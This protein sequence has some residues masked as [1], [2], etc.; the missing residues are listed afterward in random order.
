MGT[1]VAT[2]LNPRPPRTFIKTAT[3]KAQGYVII[4]VAMSSSYATNGDTLDFSTKSPPGMAPTR[5]MA[6]P[7][8]GYVPEYDLTNKKMKV[9]QQ[10]AATSALTEVPNTTNLSAVTFQC[11]VFY[12]AS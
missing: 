12:P 2:A 6:F 7:S 8:A 5:V 9:Y 1:A 10:S 11:L 4:D 3:N